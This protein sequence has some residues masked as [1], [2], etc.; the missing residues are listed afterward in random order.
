MWHGMPVL[1]GLVL[2]RPSCLPDCAHQCNPPILKST[3]RMRIYCSVVQ[4]AAW[5][6][7]TVDNVDQTA[8]ERG[9]G[10]ACCFPFIKRFGFENCL[11]RTALGGKAHSGPSAALGRRPGSLHEQFSPIC[12]RRDSVSLD[13]NFADAEQHASSRYRRKADLGCGAMPGSPAVPRL[14]PGRRVLRPLASVDGS[15]NCGL[16]DVQ[17]R[18]LALR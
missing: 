13:Q 9:L 6:K 17:P 1:R 12:S 7:K 5:L 14:R 3:S 11:H 8:E 2:S 15:G 10:G 16:P 18:P 4:A